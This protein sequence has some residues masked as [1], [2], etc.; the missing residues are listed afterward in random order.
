VGGIKGDFEGLRDLKRRIAGVE[1]PRFRRQ[2][3]KGLA[4]EARTQVHFGFQRAEDP[5][6]AAWKP[7]RSRVGQPLRDTGRLLNSIA[8]RAYPNGFTVSTQVK[9]AATHQYGATITAKNPTLRSGRAGADDQ[10]MVSTGRPMLRFRVGGARPRRNGKWVSAD[11][12]KIPRRRF[13]PEGS[14]G[15]RWVSALEGEAERIMIVQMGTGG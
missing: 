7:L 3:V 12:V 8:T 10:D 1:K 6:G 9:Y 11:S 13:I 5:E 4:E 14:I 15:L 2:L